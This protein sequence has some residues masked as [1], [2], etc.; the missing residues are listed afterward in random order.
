M[1]TPALFLLLALAASA[2]GASQSVGTTPVGF[3]TIQCLSQS[4]TVISAPLLR[5]AV[6]KGSASVSTVTAGKEGRLSFANAPFVADAYGYAADTQRETYFAVLT[7]GPRAGRFFRITGNTTDALTIALEGDA[8]DGIAGDVGVEVVPYWTL[9]TL[10][11]D[12]PPANLEVILPDLA[13]TGT[14]LTGTTSYFYSAEQRRWTD[15]SSAASRDDT[16]LPPDAYLTV[17]NRSGNDYALAP[18]GAVLSCQIAIPLS[19]D[20]AGRQDNAVALPY[21]LAVSLD[22]SGLHSSGAFTASAG[23]TPADQLYVFDNAVRQIGKAAARIYVYANGA[24]RRV[25]SSANAGGDLV[26]QPGAGV[27]IRKQRTANGAT[28]F[29]AYTPTI[30][31]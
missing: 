4:D 27:L 1:K 21:P 7:S 16:V 11:T 5:P 30:T 3:V 18:V 26:L 24:W 23:F 29:W 22:D 10:F 6:F 28:A 14:N 19:T 31:F 13:G 15:G 20:A 12:T 25:G 9:G 8:L 2:L 17:R